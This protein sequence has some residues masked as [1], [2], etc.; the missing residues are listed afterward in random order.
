MRPTNKLRLLLEE[1]GV[2]WFGSYDSDETNWNVGELTWVYINDGN[3]ASLGVVQGD[4]TPEQAIAITLGERTCKGESDLS[5]W[6][7]SECQCWIPTGITQ[8][9]KERV[10]AWN[11]CP[12]CGAKVVK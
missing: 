12:H 6:V 4:V 5:E 7:C 10:S 3:I 2:N 1:R 9:N 8:E 11:F